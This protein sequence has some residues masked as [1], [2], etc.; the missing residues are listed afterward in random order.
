VTFDQEV[1]SA[2]PAELVLMEGVRMIDEWPILEKKI[3]GFQAVFERVAGAAPSHPA[4][5]RPAKVDIEDLMAIVDD[6]SSAGEE[7]SFGRGGEALGPRESAI[8]AL[9]DGVRTVQDL[10]DIGRLG[11]FETCKVLYGLLSLNLIRIREI[12]SPAAAAPHAAPRRAGS[13][14]GAYA[15]VALAVALAFV[16]FLFNPWGIVAQ[17]FRAR[18]GRRESAALADA[19]RLRR[20]RLALEV[21]FLEKQAYPPS[22]EKLVES[23]LVRHAELRGVDGANFDYRGGGR[24]YRLEREAGR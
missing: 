20:V 11:E 9:V 23:G 12:A 15:A 4:P 22:L 21:F 5:A 8:L 18:E 17:G 1:Y 7:A 13:G 10:I 2:I 16:A 19:V 24:E 3:P 14:V 6:G